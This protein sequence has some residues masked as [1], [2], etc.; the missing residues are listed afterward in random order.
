MNM[1]TCPK[2]NSNHVEKSIAGIYHCNSCGRDFMKEGRD[3]AE[4][5]LWYISGCAVVALLIS[6]FK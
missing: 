2:C 6:V 3:F 4:I 5:M 1:P